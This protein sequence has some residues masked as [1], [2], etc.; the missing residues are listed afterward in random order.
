MT[1][2]SLQL[3][4]LKVKSSFKGIFTPFLFLHLVRKKNWGAFFFFSPDVIP[5][6]FVIYIWAFI[7]TG[8]RIWNVCWLE[9]M[10]LPEPSF[11]PSLFFKT[12]SSRKCFSKKLLCIFLFILIEG[13]DTMDLKYSLFH[14]DLNF[15]KKSQFIFIFA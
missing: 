9:K 2:V 11:C 4:S 12:W 15:S 6:G 3:L 1:F 8:G 13:R 5:Q 7:F 14:S 10:R